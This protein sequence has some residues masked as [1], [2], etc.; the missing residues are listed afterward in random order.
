M[1]VYEK[2]YWEAYINNQYIWLKNNTFWESWATFEF[3]QYASGWLCYSQIFKLE[4][5]LNRVHCWKFI[6]IRDI[7]KYTWKI[8]T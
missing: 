2:I 1:V 8:Q 5:G 6:D 7:L 4:I 3:F